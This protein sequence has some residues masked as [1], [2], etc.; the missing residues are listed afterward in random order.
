MMGQLG[1][2]DLGLVKV[3]NLTNGL[4]KTLIGQAYLARIAFQQTS[5]AN[6]P[7][8]SVPTAV[9]CST[10]TCP[11]LGDA[12][13]LNAVKDFV[14]LVDLPQSALANVTLNELVVA[15][16][17]RSALPWEQESFIGW[18]GFSGQAQKLQYHLDFDAV[19]PISGLS[20]RVRMPFGFVYVPGSSTVQIG[21]AAAR[22]VADPAQNAKTGATYTNIPTAD[23]TTGSQHVRLNFQGEPGFRLGPSPVDGGHHG[24]WTARRSTGA[25]VYVQREPRRRR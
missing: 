17:P 24:E 6:I 12:A 9:T 2:L 25:P 16:T 15:M 1:S 22:A 8:S 21:T 23:C 11:T 3:S 19:C 13:R 7:T 5:I 10:T 14:Q 20:V 18:Q 4:A